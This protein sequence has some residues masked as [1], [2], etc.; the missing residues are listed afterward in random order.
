LCLDLLEV[1]V[2]AHRRNQS[3][4]RLRRFDHQFE[5][6]EALIDCG[7]CGRSAP[8]S[9]KDAS[10][11]CSNLRGSECG[12]RASSSFVRQLGQRRIGLWFCGPIPRHGRYRFTL[13][14]IR[15]QEQRISPKIGDVRRPL[16]ISL[17]NGKAGENRRPRK[18]PTLLG[19]TVAPQPSIE[20]ARKAAPAVQ[21]LPDNKHD[22][23]AVRPGER[24]SALS[25]CRDFR[26]PGC[27]LR[28]GD[29]R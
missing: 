3:Q 15:K 18:G 13:R 1:V 11:S 8:K 6:R 10:R 28:N 21:H 29:P 20:P 5:I 17:Q 14:S 12:S 25:S 26:P 4:Q 9:L 23:S 19:P 7:L 27:G 24:P 22:S 2:D 16:A